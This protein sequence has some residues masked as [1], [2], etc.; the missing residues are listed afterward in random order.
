MKILH[1]VMKTI[2]NFN[3]MNEFA[4]KLKVVHLLIKVLFAFVLNANINFIN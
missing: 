2:L 3:S 1:K 4:T